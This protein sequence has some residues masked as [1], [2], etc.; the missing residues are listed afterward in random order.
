MEISFINILVSISNFLHKSP[1]FILI[2]S[3]ILHK[4]IFNNVTTISLARKFY[5]HAYEYKVLKIRQ[6]S[7]IWDAMRFCLL[8]TPPPSSRSPDFYLTLNYLKSQ[9]FS[10]CKQT[11]RSFKL[12]KVL[13]FLSHMDDDLNIL[14]YGSQP[15][16]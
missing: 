14:V 4:L 3:T 10:S 12:K 7:P 16:K 13:F 5:Y 11:Q 9:L 15:L 8:W 6:I 1:S 2:Y